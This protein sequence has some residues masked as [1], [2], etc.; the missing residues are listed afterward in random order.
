MK[1]N[2]TSSFINTVPFSVFISI[3]PLSE[4]AKEIVITPLSYETVSSKV[5][6]AAFFFILQCP[7]AAVERCQA[8]HVCTADLAF[9]CGDDPVLP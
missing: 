5:H 7:F 9:Q 4:T 2:C 1:R 3:Q 8:V 6:F